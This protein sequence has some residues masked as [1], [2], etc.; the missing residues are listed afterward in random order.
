M[1]N[2]ANMSNS[3]NMLNIF[4]CEGI[5]STDIDLGYDEIKKVSKATF[6]LKNTVKTGRKAYTNDFY[7]VLYGKKAE[8]CHSKLSVGEK[9]SVSGSISTWFNVDDKGNKTSG[10]VINASN[11]SC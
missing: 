11:F 5:V 6:H 9:C 4:A 7:V 3:S 2:V 1:S 8:E 10:A